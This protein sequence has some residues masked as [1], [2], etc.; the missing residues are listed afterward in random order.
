MIRPAKTIPYRR[1]RAKVKPLRGVLVNDK[2]QRG[3]GRNQQETVHDGQQ[4][5]ESPKP[6]MVDVVL[7]WHLRFAILSVIE[8]AD[9]EL[10][11]E[12]GCEQHTQN[13]MV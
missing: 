6:D 11:H 13:L 5:Q 9:G 3:V 8:K 1:L 4:D 10:D 12:E 2:A 7:G